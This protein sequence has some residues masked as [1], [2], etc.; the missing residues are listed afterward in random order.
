MIRGKKGGVQW[1]LVA[2]FFLI[3]VAL[4]VSNNSLTT[5]KNDIGVNQY[6]ILQQVEKA[7]AANTYIDK[8]ADLSATLTRSAFLESAGVYQQLTETGDT[9]P[10]ACGNYLYPNYNSKTK[11]CMPKYSNTIKNYFDDFFFNYLQH[12]PGDTPL[13]FLY[14]LNLAQLSSQELALQ[15]SGEEV[16]LPFISKSTTDQAKT[17][18][19]KDLF[20]IR[21][22][23][24]KTALGFYTKEKPITCSTGECF[25]QVT[26]LL[27]ETYKT[28]NKKYAYIVNGES[29]YCPQD[30]RTLSGYVAPTTTPTQPSSIVSLTDTFF[31]RLTIPDDR[32]TQRTLLP[33]GFDSAG[34]VWWVA[35]HANITFFTNREGEATYLQQAEA[36][37]LVCKQKTCTLAYLLTN[38]EPGDI[39]FLRDEQRVREDGSDVPGGGIYIAIYI[40][41]DKIAGK[42]II[43]HAD[44]KKGLV[45]EFLPEKYASGLDTKIEAIFR[46]SYQASGN[47][48]LPPDLQVIPPF[49][50]PFE[51]CDAQTTVSAPSQNY[52]NQL[53]SKPFKSPQLTYY[54][55]AIQTAIDSG[56]DP[57]LLVTHMVLESSLG[58]NDKCTSQ[59]KSSLTGC[60]WPLSC[61]AGCGCT[62]Q[63]V[64]SDESQ[65]SCT[66]KTD[67]GAYKEALDGVDAVTGKYEECSAYK[68]TPETFWNCIFCIYQGS[69]EK[70]IGSGKQYFVQDKTCEYAE[71]AKGLYCSW[72]AYF[73]ANWDD[74]SALS[75]L[76]ITSEL[77]FTPAFSTS[78]K[79]D[80]ATMNFIS[81]DFIPELKTCDND[82]ETCVLAKMQQFNGKHAKNIIITR[83]KEDN[84][85]ADDVVEQVLDCRFNEQK[86]CICPIVTDYRGLG[87]KHQN[88]IFFSNGTFTAE[89]KFVYEFPFNPAIPTSNLSLSQS[90][91]ILNITG[92]TQDIDDAKLWVD[93]TGAGKISTT[94][95]P[96]NIITPTN[97]AG[98]QTG[99]DVLAFGLLKQTYSSMT[100]LPYQQNVTHLTCEDNKHYFSFQ[101]E[102]LTT[103]DILKFSVYLNDV[104]P[105]QVRPATSSTTGVC[106]ETPSLNPLGFDS[107]TIFNSPLVNPSS[108]ESLP[109]TGQLDILGL[110]STILL[111]W[112]TP[113]N[114]EEIYSFIIEISEDVSFKTNVGQQNVLVATALELPISQQYPAILEQ[115]G[116]QSGQVNKYFFKVNGKSPYGKSFEDNIDYYYRIT[117]V[118][119]YGNNGTSTQTSSFKFLDSQNSPLPLSD[120]ELSLLKAGTQFTTSNYAANFIC[121]H[122]KNMF[123]TT[124]DLIP[125][126]A[127]NLK[128]YPGFVNPL[129]KVSPLYQIT[130][131]PNVICDETQTSVGKI[132]AGNEQLVTELK[133]LSPE[134]KQKGWTMI[135]TQAHR[136]WD[137][138]YKLWELSGFDSSMACNPGSKDDPKAKLCP[139]QVGGAIDIQ[140]VD[141]A[142]SKQIDYVQQESFMCQHGFVRYGKEWWHFEMG[143]RKWTAAED[144]RQTTTSCC[145]YGAP[146]LGDT[147]GQICNI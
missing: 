34:W 99:T 81:Q 104:K 114:Q 44:P 74:L 35:K 36:Q 147:R 100:W 137:I 17:Y 130:D 72:R 115:L 103:G 124:D 78:T 27:Y 125:K 10:S 58:K 59:Q 120:T 83:L 85:L 41:T 128:I 101:A 69:Y 106:L 76:H 15:A 33:P 135:I 24:P 112:E 52:I 136:S 94:T 4:L 98:S 51:W 54:D 79:M 89:G 3:G 62:G 31:S 23:Y 142:T 111:K 108:I 46:P 70:V 95:N 73:D 88:M 20:L 131:I 121:I 11:D 43:I 84:P 9:V 126:T 66:A 19:C 29:P 134:L 48:L 57:A 141:L 109:F 30:V 146:H 113:S 119:N 25:A 18:T 56:V 40:E 77:T 91:I 90:A 145:Y 92:N 140:I 68:N 1:P 133:K 61:A 123:I 110:S 143:T 138:Q 47:A 8:A 12:Y 7:A 75:S 80:L 82:L 14:D 116:V 139:H 50:G 107:Q 71:R 42:P 60:G 122:N 22:Q 26:N 102:I 28:Q 49:I 105:P 65:T 87:K 64:V 13:Y 97:P 132:C 63:W 93:D 118:D 55:L 67:L 2:L 21:K 86:D 45:K 117:P 6:T 5:V 16:S 127:S 37:S 39:L 96:W 32:F 144:A 53:S 38:A 129:D